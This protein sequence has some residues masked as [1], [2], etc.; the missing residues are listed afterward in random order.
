MVD[1][2]VI[3]LNLGCGRV[4]IPGFINADIT[5][6]EGV[7][8]VVDVSNLKALKKYEWYGKVD[9]VYLSHVLEHFPTAQ[10]PSLLKDLFDLTGEGGTVRIAVPDLDRICTLY[11]ENIDWFKPPHSPWLGL[12]YGGQTDQYDFHKTGFNGAYLE[13]L[14]HDAGFGNIVKVDPSNDLGVLDAS[15]SNL[16]FGNISLNV[17][18]MKG[19]GTKVLQ[20]FQYT[21]VEG[22]L[23]FLADVV[24]KG[25]LV[26]VRVRIALIRRRIRSAVP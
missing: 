17:E 3:R 14:L 1:N 20:R 15:Q 11:V 9:F 5:P 12:I 2:K 25:L 21:P 23:S 18:A 8:L 10:I 4:I 26:L 6:S 22:M 7:D 24:T 16:P 19:V 13:C